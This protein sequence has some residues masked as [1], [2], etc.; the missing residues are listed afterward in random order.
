[1]GEFVSHEPCPKC[2]SKDNLAR[3]KDGSG[4]CFGCEYFSLD[5]N[6]FPTSSD[7]VI[8]TYSPLS[9]RKISLETCKFFDY[10]VGLVNNESV[11]IANYKNAEGRI[12]AQKIRSKDKKFKW[13]GKEKNTGLY[14]K[15]LWK[16]NKKLTIVITEGEIDALSVAESQHCAWPVV[17]IST[18]AGPQTK[19]QIAKEIEYLNAF[20]Q[21]V[22]L[23]DSDEVGRKT[24]KECALNCFSDSSSSQY[25]L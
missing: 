6:D 1:M 16:P 25:P 13:G 4:Y 15:W 7:H 10:R 20:K 21:V 3:Y 22:F 5:A 9:K 12:V 19:R 8:G 2:G 24:A 23:F 11:Q 18:G 17:S 14:G